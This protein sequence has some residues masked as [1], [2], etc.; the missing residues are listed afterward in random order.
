MKYQGSNA[1]LIG[2]PGSRARL[3]TPALVLDLDALERNIQTMAGF[4]RERGVALRPHAK[5]H[6]SG[7]IARMQV[8]AGA[9]GV[10]V[11]TIG[12]AEAM[13]DADIPGVLITSP[14]VPPDKIARLMALNARADGLMV[15]ADNPDNVDALAAAGLP[16][17]ITVD[18][19]M[20]R[21]RTGV[22]G[23]AEGV[24][25]A[26]RIAA[27]PALE[28]AG[29]T[30][31]AGHVQHV[32]DFAERR[33]QVIEA[34]TAAI[35]LRKGLEQAGLSVPLISGAGTGSHAIDGDG[36]PYT[37]LQV[38]SYI[39]TDVEYDAVALC[40]DASKPFEAALFV[41][42]TVVS[43]NA[44]GF[45]TTNAGSKRFAMDG[46]PPAVVSGAPAGSSYGFMGDEHGKLIL[47]DGGQR[48][49]LGATIVCLTPHCDPTVNLYDAYHVVRGDTLVDIWPVDARGAV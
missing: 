47:G 28:F 24:A 11:A 16:L 19:N 40:E 46:P 10:C 32:E 6:K 35:E 15:T 33:R 21:H 41:Q 9:L 27:A 22:S 14:V 4:A 1:D 12:E 3:T 37:E 45:V 39:F 23:A 43:T 44:E 31:Y 29:I 26:R 38:G 5:T 49:A 8:E 7:H 36:G 18:L 20:G 48:P 13:V 34:N 30:A 2:Q 17:R 42:S 25:L